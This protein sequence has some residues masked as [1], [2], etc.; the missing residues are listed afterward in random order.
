MRRF[1]GTG[2]AGEHDQRIAGN[3]DV[4]IFQVVFACAANLGEAARR[5]CGLLGVI[6]RTFNS[7]VA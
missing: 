2:H 7:R 3:V 4:D 5:E 1:P 6:S